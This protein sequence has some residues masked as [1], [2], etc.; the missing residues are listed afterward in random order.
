MIFRGTLRQ[1]L[2]G[3]LTEENSAATQAQTDLINDADILVACK[4]SGLF[5]IMHHFPNGL[6]SWIVDG[7]ENLS[8][9]ERQL[10][11][12]TRMFLRDPAILLL[13]EA[14]ASI[15]KNYETL[16]Q[17]AIDEALIGRTCFTIAHRLSTILKSDLI[18]VFEKG[19]IVERG[20]HTELMAKR[21]YYWKLAERQQLGN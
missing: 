5:Q 14:T 4:R 7:G 10:I 13:E 21:G 9:G 3:A 15:D 8:M 19:N 11:A 17:N 2:I 20:T 16:I 12:F 18:L 1:N 6:D